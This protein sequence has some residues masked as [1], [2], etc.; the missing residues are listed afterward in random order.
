LENNSTGGSGDGC[1]KEP[2]ESKSIKINKTTIIIYREINAWLEL[3][4]GGCRG[5]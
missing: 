3:F 1:I 2:R 4:Q 5:E